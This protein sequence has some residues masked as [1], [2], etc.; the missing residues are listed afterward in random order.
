MECARSRDIILW[1]ERP[2]DNNKKFIYAVFAAYSSNNNEMQHT[3][4]Q[5]LEHHSPCAREYQP[6]TANRVHINMRSDYAI[7]FRVTRLG[8]TDH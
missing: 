3:C 8:T 7:K 6:Q 1:A 5:K 2:L 4:S